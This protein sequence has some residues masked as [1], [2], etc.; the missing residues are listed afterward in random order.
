MPALDRSFVDALLGHGWPGN[1]RELEKTLRRAIVLAQGEGVL[2]PEHLPAEIMGQLGA[3][4][5]SEE[6]APLKE[7][8]AVI[9]CRE[10]TRALQASGGN[11]SAAARNLKISYPNLLKKIRHYGI[12][13]S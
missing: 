10:I 6:I 9:E 1:V 2:R 8:L 11:K 12:E 3:S 5:H 7:T 4:E 13:V